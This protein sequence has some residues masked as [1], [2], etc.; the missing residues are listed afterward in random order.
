ME[1]KRFGRR[2]ILTLGLLRAYGSG[3]AE[4]GLAPVPGRAAEDLYHVGLY[5]LA[6]AAAEADPDEIPD[7][8]QSA[9]LTARVVYGQLC[10]VLEDV[11]AA[12]ET[13]QI[14]V[15]VLKGMANAAELYRQ[16][17][18][19]VMGDV[20]VL[21]AS[22]HAENLYRRLVE[23]G[24]VPR[25]PAL[26]MAH[27]EG[28][29][30]LQPL[31]HPKSRVPVEIHTALFSSS[32]PARHSF[33]EAGRVLASTR[34]ADFRG[35]RCLKLTSEMDLLY[36]IAHWAADLRWST[37]AV[38]LCDIVRM[39]D[40]RGSTLDWRRID[41]WLTENPLLCDYFTVVMILLERSGLT[42]IPR[43]VGHNVARSVDRVGERNLRVLHW[44]IRNYPL[45]GRRKV[46][47][48]LTREHAHVAWRTI[49][50][51]GDRSR[52]LS[53]AAWRIV[54]LR[55]QP[56]QSLIASLLKRTIRAV[57]SPR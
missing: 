23:V 7:W 31:K 45:S 10:T 13:E 40:V 14:R 12:A 20:D 22:Q 37:N 32:S 21:V 46:G 51:P 17:H 26:G 15:V 35:N 8:L 27:N 28:S 42:S 6:V 36:T 19:R 18:H 33:F 56:G 30:H 57:K 43:E 1:N 16:P 38:G 53:D 44:L 49:L 11:L 4:S 25:D 50:E 5:Y 41:G 39:L 55:R 29:H 34:L 47:G 3:E 24:Y 54:T 48:L 52:R 9:E 2:E